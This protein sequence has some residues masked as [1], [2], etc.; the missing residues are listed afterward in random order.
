MDLCYQRA[1]PAATR[2][3]R[4]SPVVGALGGLLC[5]AWF[6]ATGEWSY[7]IGDPSPAGVLADLL[8][9]AHPL[10]GYVVLVLVGA[11]LGLVSL[12]V[13]AATR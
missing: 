3:D 9:G 11:G 12:V 5:A 1:T 10:V 2:A 6:H 13:R 4:C 8:F 7:G